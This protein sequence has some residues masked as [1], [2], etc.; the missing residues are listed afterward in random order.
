MKKKIALILIGLLALTV[1][2]GCGK[3][4]EPAAEPEAAQTET[5]SPE[6]EAPAEPSLAD[7]LAK[8]KE[9]KGMSYDMTMTAPGVTMNGH[10]WVQGKNTKMDIMVE[11]Q[12][13]VNII[14]ADENVAYLYMPDQK[15]AMKM[16]IDS[17]ETGGSKTP[18]EN[19]D[20][21]DPAEYEMGEKVDLNGMACRLVTHTAADGT[22]TRM[23]VSEELGIPMK[24]E[25]TAADGQVTTMEYS[26][27]E[28]GDLPAD[29]FKLPEGTEIIGL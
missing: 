8:G 3:K 15:M 27:L 26:N 12:Q 1:A 18:L 20:Q 9:I 22:A 11:G 13:A 23:W 10:F 7:L 25:I 28:V 5:E 21:I 14:N 17:I 16:P 4:E 6:A 29:T 24:V 19:T 2:F